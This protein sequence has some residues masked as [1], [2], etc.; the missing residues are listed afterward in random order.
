MSFC[1]IN[2][3]SEREQF[4][5]VRAAADKLEPKIRRAFLRAVKEVQGTINMTALATALESGNLNGALR[6]VGVD[7]LIPLLQ[8]QGMPIDENS[9][10]EEWASTFSAG[11]NAAIAALPKAIQIGMSFTLVN[12][13]A[14]ETIDAMAGEAIVGITNNTRIA[15]RGVIRRGFTDRISPVKMAREIRQMVG[16]TDGMSQAVLNYRRGLEDRIPGT[17]NRRISGPDKQIV[18]RHIKH[19]G[20]TQKQ[21]NDLTAKYNVSL[22]NRRALNIARTETVRASNAGQNELWRQGIDQGYIKRNARKKWLPT[23]DKRLRDNHRV[24]PSMNSGGVRVNAYFN[25]PTGPALSPPPPNDAVNCRCGM[26]LVRG[27]I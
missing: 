7:R 19:G 24:I 25:T 5:Q 11:G 23:Y 27:T 4:N 20:L 6:I 9:F 26:A 3:I 17:Q 12:P 14:V 16:L 15:V 18:R 22:L 10:K 2:K 13:R 1:N 8:G 21:I